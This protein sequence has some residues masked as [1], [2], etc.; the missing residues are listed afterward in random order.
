MNTREI[1]LSAVTAERDK[2]DRKWGVRRD[3]SHPLWFTI[4]GEEVGEVAN[5]IL[6]GKHKGL[7]KELIQVAAVAV[8]FAEAL[9]PDGGI[10]VPVPVTD[11]PKCSTS[12][13]PTPYANP[14]RS[15]L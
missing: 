4:L 14:R 8:A 5:A 11:P 6:E 2:Q 10:G 15:L 9:L 3:Q 13:R 1:V 7:Y 12:A